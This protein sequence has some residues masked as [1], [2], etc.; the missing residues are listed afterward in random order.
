[1][2]A[3]R[4]VSDLSIEETTYCRRVTLIWVFF[5][6]ANG[7]VAYD[8]ACC[9]SL[10]IWSLYNGFLAYIMVGLLFTVELIYRSWRFRRYSGFPAD[11]IF[12]KVFPPKA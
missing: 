11:F 7:M 12:K 4:F 5:S 8:T 6:A 9:T 10:K 2:Y 3:R 1:M